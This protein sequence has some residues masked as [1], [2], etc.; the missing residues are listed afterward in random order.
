MQ[1]SLSCLICFPR[2]SKQL[3]VNKKKQNK[4]LALK[5]KTVTTEFTP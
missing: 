5:S 2:Y 1:P 3:R 4:K